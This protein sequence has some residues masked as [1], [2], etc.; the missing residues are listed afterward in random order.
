M[1]RYE[2]LLPGDLVPDPRN[3]DLHG[4]VQRHIKTQLSGYVVHDPSVQWQATR[5]NR[6]KQVSG[7]LFRGQRFALRQ[8]ASQPVHVCIN[9]LFKI[10]R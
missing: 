1:H 6:G 10:D 8:N 3:R 5:V 4:R 7:T 9:A 2:S